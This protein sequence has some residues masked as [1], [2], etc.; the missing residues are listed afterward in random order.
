MSTGAS[1]ASV[2]EVRWH[3]TRK[4]KKFVAKFFETLP[5]LGGYGLHE[6]HLARMKPRTAGGA[7]SIREIRAAGS[8]VSS[9]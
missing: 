1:S 3:G 2:D 8:G 7:R 6:G 9:G 4:G 5:G